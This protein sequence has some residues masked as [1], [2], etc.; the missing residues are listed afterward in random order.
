MDFVIISVLIVTLT[1]W[2]LLKTYEDKNATLHQT[3]TTGF[4]DN[5]K[6]GFSRLILVDC[7]ARRRLLGTHFRE[8]DRKDSIHHVCLDIFRLQR[9]AS[10]Q[11][12]SN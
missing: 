10:A 3:T 1:Q 8:G 9:S 2:N 5:F 6:P 7:D 11:R 4:S 12:P